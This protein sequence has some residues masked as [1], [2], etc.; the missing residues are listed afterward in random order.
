MPMKGL[1]FGRAYRGSHFYALTLWMDQFFQHA[2]YLQITV[3]VYGFSLM[4]GLEDRAQGGG[5]Q[6]FDD[7]GKH[8]D[9][10]AGIFIPG[11]PVP[12]GLDSS[13]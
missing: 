12:V 1:L 8:P 4:E 7:F 6:L 9:G 13:S 3:S 5:A 10:P 11:Y 2:L